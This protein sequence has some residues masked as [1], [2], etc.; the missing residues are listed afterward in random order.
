MKHAEEEEG[1]W[2]AIVSGLEIGRNVGEGEGEGKDELRREML[3][4]WLSGEL[5]EEGSKEGD[6][7]S[8]RGVHLSSVFVEIG[9]NQVVGIG[10]RW[11]RRG[12]F[13][14]TGAGGLGGRSDI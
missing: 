3:R 9:R 2:V 7:V 5:E 13:E 14:G 11:Y 1:G 4:E 12:K 8:F 10:A 6:E